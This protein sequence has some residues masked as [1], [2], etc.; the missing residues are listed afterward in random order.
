MP[1]TANVATAPDVALV[2]PVPLV[3]LTDGRITCEMQGKVA[4][5]SRAWKTFKDLDMLRGGMPVDVFIYASH[6]DGHHDFE[7]SWRGR[8]IGQVESVGGAHPDKMRFRPESTAS[9]PSDNSGYWAVFWEVEDLHE[10]PEKER[11]PL[12]QFTGY[13]KKKAY[14]HAFP[15]EGPLLVKHP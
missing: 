5:G 9:H 4:F 13:D 7:V 1:K 12:A 8:Y 2:A 15:P 6:A 11:V 3:H 10:L 14:G